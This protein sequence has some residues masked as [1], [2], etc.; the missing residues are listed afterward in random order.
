[1]KPTLGNGPTAPPWALLGH[2]DFSLAHLPN[3]SVS[4]LARSFSRPESGAVE[5]VGYGINQ[6]LRRRLERAAFIGGKQD[7]QLP[8]PLVATR[9][10]QERHP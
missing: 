9:G 6:I 1:M 5:N 8:R 2:S 4:S 3:A 10:G 7:A